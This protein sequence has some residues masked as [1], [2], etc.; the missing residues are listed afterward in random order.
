[1]DY[2]LV[3]ERAMPHVQHAKIHDDVLGSD[4]CPV[5]LTWQA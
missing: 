1:L 5:S 4:H 3:S 2:M